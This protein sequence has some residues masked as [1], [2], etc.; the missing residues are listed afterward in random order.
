MAALLTSRGYAVTLLLNEQATMQGVY[1]AC[2]SAGTGMLAGDKLFVYGSSH[3]GQVPDYNGDE[4]DRLD[5]T[6]CLWD[7]QFVDDRVRELTVRV[8]AGVEVDMMTD[9]CHSEGNFRGVPPHVYRPRGVGANVQCSFTHYAGCGE[10][11][12]SY[13]GHEGGVFTNKMLGSFIDKI[14]RKGWFDAA[15]GK[16]PANQKPVFATMGVSVAD[17]EALA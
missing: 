4:S 15:A 11:K 7:G 17:K 16:M 3:G 12:F 10:S 6:I 9:C 13:G 5:E 1:D 2:V 14:S 8:P